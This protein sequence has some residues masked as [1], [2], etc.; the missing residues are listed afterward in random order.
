MKD[1]YKR[2]NIDGQE[3]SQRVKPYIV[4]ELSANHNGSIDNAIELITAPNDVVQ[5]QSSC[6]HIRPTR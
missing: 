1:D 5:T 4:A 2:V 6:R 3:I